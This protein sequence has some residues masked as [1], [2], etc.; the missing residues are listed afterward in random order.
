MSYEKNIF[1]LWKTEPYFTAL[2][3]RRFEM[4]PVCGGEIKR[5]LALITIGA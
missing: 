3:L 2:G 1:A 5:T 4:G